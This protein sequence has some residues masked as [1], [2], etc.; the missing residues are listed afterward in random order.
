M[1]IAILGYGTVGIGVKEITKDKV[2]KIFDLPIKKDQIGDTY[3]DSFSDIIEN[4][5]I[6]TVVETM[7]GNDFPYKLIV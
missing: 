7:G 4:P 2:L 6:Q 5:D 1:N 3:T